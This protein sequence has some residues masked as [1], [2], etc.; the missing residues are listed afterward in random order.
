M[1]KNR[2]LRKISGHKEEEVTGDWRK[3]RNEELHDLCFSQN[4]IRMI[5]KE[6]ELGRTCST[7]GGEEK[8]I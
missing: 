6:H 1:S 5:I 4:I 3:L 8:C 2:I 7:Y